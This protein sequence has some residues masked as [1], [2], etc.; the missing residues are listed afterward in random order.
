LTVSRSHPY[1]C[2]PRFGAKI[3]AL[4]VCLATCVALA[5]P[6]SA[7][8]ITRDTVLARAQKW[9]D[10]PVPYSQAKYVGGY[11][12]DCSGYVS[13]VWQADRS[14]STATMHDIS[15]RITAAELRPGDVMLHAGSHVRMF[16]GWVDASKTAYVAYEQ[17]GPSTKSS[18]KY[19]A[20]DLAAGYVP[21][22]YKGVVDSPPPWN[23]VSNPR[24]NTWSSGA[25]VWWTNGANGLG[26]GWQVR[27]DIVG[28]SAFALGLTNPNSSTSSF[29][30]GLSTAAVEEG[31]TY[32]LSS[33]AGTTANPSAVSVRILVY[34]QSGAVL[35]DKATTGNLWGIGAGA[36]GP[37]S[38]AV[39]MPAGART[40]VVS[41]RLSGLTGAD[42]AAPATAVFD[43]VQ[44][45]VSSPAPVYRFYNRRNGSHFYT[46]TG[47][48]RDAVANT[49][50][51]TYTYEGIAYGVAATAANASPLYRFFNRRNGSH[52]YTASTAERDRVKS[53]L[54]ATY[55][56]EGPAYNV[57]VAPV[58]G[59][60]SVYRFYN[61]K[62]GSH[63]YTSSVSEM[64]S[65]RSRLS[66]VYT[67]EGTA[68]YLAP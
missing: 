47:T 39:V 51:S 30:E 27:K 60:T 54:S 6:V 17:T 15:Y 33:L 53:K 44:L 45:Y 63:F 57:S 5:I 16:Y 2:D 20:S 32:T 26:T 37:M 43:D 48:E 19:L 4:A 14:W 10:N 8:A 67:Y 1:L 40:A 12:T 42:G 59:A 34:N 18:I 9:V 23:A 38:I 36:L 61:R 24:F 62:N 41:L 35:A 49:L 55:T 28:S 31:K 13:M 46:A 66:R 7:A 64:E 50:T 25:P 22:R 68:F 65:V 29:A 11:R 52:F 21:Y 3:A 58:A 56:Y